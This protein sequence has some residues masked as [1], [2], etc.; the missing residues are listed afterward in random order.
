MIRQILVTGANGQLGM[1][2]ARA[3]A[4][5]GWE[6]VALGRNELDLTD[7]VAITDKVMETP[8]AAII[9]GAAYTSADKAESDQMTAW[10]VNALAPAAFASACATADIPLVQVSTDY[11]FAGDEAGARDV[12]DPVSPINVYGASKLGGE[13]AVRVSGVRHAIVRTSW[14]VSAHGNNFLKTM[15]RMGTDRDILR[16]VDDQHGSPTAAADLADALITIAMRLAQDRAA[17]TGTF[18]FSNTGAVTW[19]DFASEIFAQ[20]AVRGGP[21]AKIEPIASS[22]YPTPARRPTNSL[23]SHD[24]IRAAYGITP[25]PWQQ[26]L[27]EILDELI[28]CKA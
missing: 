24:A 23:L 10:R 16:V 26:A 27:G 3:S 19:A 15:L 20:S 11:V 6:V 4:H 2:L 21:F 12:D 14:V 18:H 25:R 17:P 28:G 1:E 13:L 22:G 5:E 9:N 7:T 8:W